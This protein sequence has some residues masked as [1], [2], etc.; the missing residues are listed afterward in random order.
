MP[1]AQK[2][3]P[4]LPILAATVKRDGANANSVS[5]GLQDIYIY[6]IHISS[7]VKANLATKTILVI[8]STVKLQQSDRENFSDLDL[9][10]VFAKPFCPLR[11][12]D[13]IS[14]AL[15]WAL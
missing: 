8:L 11:L 14:T 15:G 5:E 13:Q 7:A 9:A 6:S 1:S 2:P 12:A 3:L 4:T 10:A